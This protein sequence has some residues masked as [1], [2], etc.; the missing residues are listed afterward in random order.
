[1]FRRCRRS[2]PLAQLL[3]GVEQTIGGNLD[4]REQLLFLGS[5]PFRFGFELFGFASTSGGLFSLEMPRP[6]L[7]DPN[8]RTDP[9]RECAQ[10]KPR[11]T[12]CFGTR[13][14]RATA[15]SWSAC[16]AVADSS[17]AATASCSSRIIVS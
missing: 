5:D 14:N 13:V 9:F 11:L 2:L 17:S 6:L 10:L 16:C 15:S 12:G 7:R 8:R 1:M 3:L 4:N